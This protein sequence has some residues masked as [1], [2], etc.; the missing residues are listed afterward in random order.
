MHRTHRE[1]P[2]RIFLTQ[3]VQW[4]STWVITHFHVLSCCTDIHTLQMSCSDLI[5]FS[6][7]PQLSRYNFIV[8]VDKLVRCNMGLARSNPIIP[9]LIPWNNDKCS[10]MLFF[11]IIEHTLYIYEYWAFINSCH[12]DCRI[13]FDLNSEQG[14]IYIYY[15]LLREQC[16]LFVKNNGFRLKLP[17]IEGKICLF[18][19]KM[20]P[21]LG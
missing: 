12:A 6:S 13:V 10:L 1:S 16:W 18:W 2:Q 15:L 7:V 5:R 3:I 21:I 9:V 14:H 4:F 19:W 8:V 11:T 20:I 17:W